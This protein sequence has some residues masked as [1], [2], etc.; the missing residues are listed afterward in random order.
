MRFDSLPGEPEP[1]Q[2]RLRGIR[3]ETNR[4]KQSIHGTNHGKN[5]EFVIQ[6]IR[7]AEFCDC[8]IIDRSRAFANLGLLFPAFTQRKFFCGKPPSHLGFFE[9]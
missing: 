1:N 6:R 7:A 8:V 9:P 2:F 5:P 3:T 4:F